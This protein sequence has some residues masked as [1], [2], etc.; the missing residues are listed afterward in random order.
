MTD[1]YGLIPGD[2]AHINDAIRQWDAID[3]V[4]LFGSRA[5]GN[6]KPGS[7]VDLAVKGDRI[8]QRTLAQL[9]D[10]LNEEKPLPYFF[11]VV[12]YDTLEEQNLIDH[13]NRVGVVIYARAST[14]P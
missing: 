1:A 8:T 10:C 3:E 14:S 2:W 7:D 12:H 4:V 6:Y 11:D 9:A 13:I 5:K